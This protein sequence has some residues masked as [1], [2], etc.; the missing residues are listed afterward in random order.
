MSTR[1]SKTL[2]FSPVPSWTQQVEHS[3]RS[4]RTRLI[5]HASHQ[6]VAVVSYHPSVTCVENECS[7][8]T[9][10]NN[11]PPIWIWPIGMMWEC[12]GQ[13]LHRMTRTNLAARLLARS[14]R[15]SY[16]ESASSL[17]IVFSL[18]VDVVLVLNNLMN[19]LNTSRG[20]R[21]DQITRSTCEP[22][23]SSTILPWPCLA[24]TPAVV[25]QWLLA[26]I[27]I[28]LTATISFC[29]RSPTHF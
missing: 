22:H 20:T 19:N 17:V 1:A 18:K 13:G 15:L 4:C 26:D 10:R 23:F 12:T 7:H 6:T 11:H 5:L 8:P 16:A 27:N 24:C 21:R 28:L 14:I 9:K 25:V 29:S 3:I 2:L